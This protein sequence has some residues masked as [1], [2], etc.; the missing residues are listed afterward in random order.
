MSMGIGPSTPSAVF[1]TTTAQVIYTH[2]ALV[3]HIALYPGSAACTLTVYDNASAGSGTVL[4]FLN[5]V[6]NGA[7]VT[8]NFSEAPPR[9]NNG[10]TCALT[11]AAAT[12]QVFYQPEF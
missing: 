10:I 9:A 6:A 5:G 11:G 12:A 2:P 8:F 3:R 1:T 7:S 4:A